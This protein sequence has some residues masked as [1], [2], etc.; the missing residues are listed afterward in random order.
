M[1]AAAFF[2]TENYIREWYDLA[3]EAV[4][5][6]IE[7]DSSYAKYYCTKA[8]VLCIQRHYTQAMESINT[9]IAYE[10]SSRSDYALRISS[11]LYCKAMISDD[12]KRYALEQKF[13]TLLK[14]CAPAAVHAAQVQEVSIPNLQPYRGH[15]PSLFVSYAHV[16]AP[17]VFE[18]L[19]M[20]QKEGVCVW[21][22][23]NGIPASVDFTELDN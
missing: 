22:D 8:R 13:R 14:A 20:L 19:E 17:R 6:A 9:T 2:D 15:E 23:R 3:L 11:Y 7:L 12:C 18:I 5:H 1:S 21:F 4:N 10:S 16:D